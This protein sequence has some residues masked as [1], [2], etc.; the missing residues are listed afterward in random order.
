MTDKLMEAI[1]KV[2]EKLQTNRYMSAIRNAFTALL[3][4]TIE[5]SPVLGNLIT[6]IFCY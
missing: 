4:I 6:V 1:L 5:I 3:P 2:A